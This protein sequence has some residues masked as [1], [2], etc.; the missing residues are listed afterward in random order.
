MSLQPNEHTP[1]SM[2]DPAAFKLESLYQRSA[3]ITNL[4][5]FIRTENEAQLLEY[6]LREFAHSRTIEN[7]NDFVLALQRDICHLDKIINDQ[8]NIIIHHTKFKKLEASWRGL[9]FLVLEAIGAKNVKIKVLDI[10]WNEVVKD[11]ERSLEFDQSYLFQQVYNE[12]YGLPGGEPYGA[13][14][15]DYE[16][17]HRPCAKYPHDD[18]NAL[19]GIAQVAAASFSPFIASCSSEIFGM[20]DFSGL[21]NPVDLEKIFSQQEYIPWQALRE[22]VDTRFIGL[23]LPRI[24]MRRPYRQTPGSYKGLFFYEKNMGSSKDSY[25]WGNACYGFA[26]ILIREFTSVGWFGHIR[27]VPRNQ[28]GGGLLTN[29]PVVDF[30]T[31][32]AD[33]AHKPTTDVIITD[34]IE[35]E[36]AELGF[37]PLCQC[38]DMP[39]AAF[40][41]NTSIFKKKSKSDASTKLSAMLQHVLCGSRV[42]HYIKIMIRN[43]IGSFISAEE[44]ENYLRQWLFQYTDNRTDLEWD[45]QAR[46]PLRRAKVT[47]KDHPEKPGHY[48]T[49]IHLVPHYQLDNMVSELELVTELAQAK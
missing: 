18:L 9:D 34:S 19:A 15:G 44:C 25:L 22:K 39:F 8:L 37:I 36:I 2:D 46:F 31:D 29:L 43:K 26:S 40:Y 42:A 1:S 33:V 35:K 13:L 6:W 4:D 17:N 32:A 41:S 12:E 11:M 14:I 16:I 38:Y 23:T 10:S 49:V 24:L 28:I 48:A 7:K 3:Y 30:E 45:E 21:A 5:Q 47:V 20:D 27:G